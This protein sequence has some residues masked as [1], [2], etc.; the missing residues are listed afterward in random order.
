[1]MSLTHDMTGVSIEIDVREFVV[2]GA[3]DAVERAMR[4][5][6]PIMAAIGD[7]PVSSTHMRFVTQSSPVHPRVCGEQGI[8]HKRPGLVC[9][10]SPRVRGTAPAE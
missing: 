1:M 5:S 7:C 10:S 9:G 3:F 8:R 2:R 4:D 6:E